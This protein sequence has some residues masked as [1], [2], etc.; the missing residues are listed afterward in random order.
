[1]T[2]EVPARELRNNTAALLRRAGAGERIVVT[3][4]GKPVASLVSLERDRR[5]WI[6]HAELLRRL[7]LVQADPG[8]RRDLDRLAGEATDQL[9]PIA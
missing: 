6:S 3:V 7:A 2:A 5:S 9:G 4:R 8:L 1:M